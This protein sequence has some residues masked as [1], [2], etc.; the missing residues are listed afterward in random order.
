[1]KKFIYFILIS[2]LILFSTQYVYP[3]INKV[4]LGARY[5]KLGNT[6]RISKDFDLSK[7][8]IT[9]GKKLVESKS[10]YWT[11]VAYE[12]LGYYY[13]DTEKDK[14]KAIENL[15]KAQLMY[16]QIV[17]QKDGSQ[18]ALA[19]LMDLIQ[20]ISNNK[21]ENHGN[22]N[23]KKKIIIK[24]TNDNNTSNSANV[25][26]LDRQK[27]REL[28]NNLPKNLSNL[29][30][31]DNKFR[32]FPDELLQYKN[33][34]FLNLSNNK[35]KS[36]PENINKLDKLEYLDLSKNKLKK[37]P[38]SLGQMKNL[39]FLNLK[40]NKISFEDISNLIRALPNTNILFDEFIRKP[41][42]E[43]GEE[44]ELPLE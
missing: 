3:S 23:I 7:K 42:A 12:Y 24:K 38:S 20:F 15:N 39:R 5:L 36:L 44:E 22:I 25:I 13:Y 31:A 4:E 17:N 40:D 10:E 26:N 35:I 21:I 43:T 28:P 2:S 9:K 34:Q 14:T 18:V 27:L 41:D 8:Y 33:L 16:K 30:L 29:S 32:N 37:L 6:Y 19:S 11:A 1:M